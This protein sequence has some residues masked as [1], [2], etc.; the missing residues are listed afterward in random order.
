METLTLNLKTSSKVRRATLDGRAYLVAPFTSIVPGVLNGSKGPIFYP[1]EENAKNPDAWNGKPL[2]LGHP[3]INGMHV[4]ARRPDILDSYGLGMIFESKTV[5]GKLAGEAWFDIEKVKKVHAP[6]LNALE[7]GEPVEISTGLFIDQEPAQEGAVY[8]GKA[9]SFIARN[10]K[11]DHLAIL[12]DQFGACSVKDGCGVH[13]AETMVEEFY[14]PTPTLLLK[15]VQCLLHN[16]M[17]VN[18]GGKGSGRPGPCP[19]FK[20]STPKAV[21]AKTTPKA[22]AKPPAKALP[23]KVA[24]KATSKVGEL[25][26]KVAEA[27]KNLADLQAQLKRARTE[28]KAAT[29]AKPVK[30]N[31]K[32]AEAAAQLKKLAD[33]MVSKARKGKGQGIDRQKLEQDFN[34]LLGK[35]SPN[36]VALAMGLTTKKFSSRAKAVTELRDAVIGRVG[37]SQ[38]TFA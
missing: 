18:C 22:P 17:C 26:Q 21:P 16:G 7:K 38:R 11:P 2:T 13:N 33:D 5:D 37:L 9:Y 28:A 34:N 36:A 3:V 19:G 29:P 14:P 10:Y 32:A 31:K 25:R 4:S 12:V 23:A 6:L 20:R 1:A 27:K 15:G 24:P 30:E 35:N 8:N